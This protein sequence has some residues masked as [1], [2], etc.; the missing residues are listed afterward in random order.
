MAT[1]RRA[2]IGHS[3]TGDDEFTFEP[4]PPPPAPAKAPTPRVVRKPR[5]SVEAVRREKRTKFIE[6]MKPR[7]NRAIH[8][9]G[10]LVHGSNR[11]RYHYTPEDV[12]VMRT[13]LLKQVEEALKPYIVKLEDNK[14]EFRE[15]E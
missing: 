13:A 6:V 4:K 11:K 9:I 5:R 2:K 14:V 1:S 12:Q 10:L 3:S 8:D 15:D 7:V